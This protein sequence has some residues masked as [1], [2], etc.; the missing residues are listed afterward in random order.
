MDLLAGYGSDG[1]DSDGGGSPAP[2]PPKAAARPAP[3]PVSG[4]Q[5]LLS[6]LP[7]PKVARASGGASL[8]SSLP[9]PRADVRGASASGTGKTVQWRPPISTA[10]LSAANDEEERPKKV[11][12]STK[13]SSL[14][15]ML[16]KPKNV[17]GVGS[18]GGTEALL[19]GGSSGPRP[20]GGGGSQSHHSPASHPAAAAAA[21][22]T[23]YGGNN[24]YRVDASGAYGA[25]AYSAAAST[26]TAAPHHYSAAPAA[27]PQRSGIPSA[28][29]SRHYDYNPQEHVVATAYEGTLET[30]QESTAPVQQ[31]VSSGEAGNG[32]SLLQAELERE[33]DRQLKLGR[34]PGKAPKIVNINQEKLKYVAPTVNAA[35]T[36]AETAFGPQY[37]AQLR[38][39]AGDKG[40]KTARRK[41]QIGTLFHE[42]KLAELD[43]LEKRSTG[44]KSKAE[45]AAKYGW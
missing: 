38:K 25:H 17:L 21:P 6:K 7:A 39:E 5:S 31:A 23:G 16:P 8:F 26:A 27:A 35:Q 11:S 29:P 10:A 4:N 44:Q 30:L 13:G 22:S 32:L 14:M 12:K 37:K 34:K 45:T 9:P 18:G 42:S 36:A 3:A 40:S 15:S 41:H 33:R 19:G 20:L 24:I 28:G 2:A 43:M 1:D